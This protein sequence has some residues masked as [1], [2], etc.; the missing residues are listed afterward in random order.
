V[1]DG[2]ATSGLTRRAET[3]CRRYKRRHRPHL[4]G[5]HVQKPLAEYVTGFVMDQNDLHGIGIV[6]S[7]TGKVLAL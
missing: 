3:R 6:V 2:D 5:Q 1:Q 4:R 7:E